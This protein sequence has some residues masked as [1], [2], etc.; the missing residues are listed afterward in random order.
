MEDTLIDFSKNPANPGCRTAVGI[1]NQG[2]GNSSLEKGFDCNVH[3]SR[4][5][6]CLW[7]EGGELNTQ[8][9]TS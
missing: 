9:S 8:L 1:V 2:G 3:D 6:S 5:S 7:V 4:S